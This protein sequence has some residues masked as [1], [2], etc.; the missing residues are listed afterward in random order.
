MIVVLLCILQHLT[1]QMHLHPNKVKTEHM[2]KSLC[3][4]LLR[5]NNARMGKAEVNQMGAD[6]VNFNQ[7]F[8]S[9]FHE[10][11][12]TFVSENDIR[13]LPCSTEGVI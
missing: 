8:L 5:S 4:I 10:T 1:G 6:D 3:I 12:W 7:V 13:V 9:L 11:P 2:Y